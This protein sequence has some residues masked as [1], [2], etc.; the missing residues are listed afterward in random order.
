MHFYAKKI[1]AI[2]VTMEHLKKVVLKITVKAKNINATFCQQMATKI[3]LIYARL[4][5]SVKNVTNNLRIGLDYGD[6]KKNALTL[7][8]MKR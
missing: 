8:M 4:N 2:F 5:I 7:K 3:M 6:T 1:I